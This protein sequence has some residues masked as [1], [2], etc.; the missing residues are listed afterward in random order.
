MSEKI[1]LIPGLFVDPIPE[2]HI[3]VRRL[4]LAT[5]VLIDGRLDTEPEALH[6]NL[7]NCFFAPDARVVIAGTRCP[8]PLM[9]PELVDISNV[10]KCDAIVVRLGDPTKTGDVT[11][12]IHVFGAGQA[13]VAYRLWMPQPTGTAWLVPTAGEER[14]IRLDP[15]GFDVGDDAPFSDACDRHRGLAWASE[16]LGVATKGWF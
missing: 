16:F 6:P 14:F 7:R 5:S 13:D 2:P 12:D 11:F 3:Q 8:R 4:M 1:E 10:V 9:L 15:A